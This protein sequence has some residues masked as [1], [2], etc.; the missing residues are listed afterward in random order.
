MGDG[1][2]TEPDR[3]VFVPP[4]WRIVARAGVSAGPG[5]HVLVITR[6][7]AFG[8]GRHPTTQLCLQALAAVGPRR[9]VLDFGSGSGILALAAARLSASARGVEID[10]RALAVSRDNAR[11][12]GLDGRVAFGRAVDDGTYD[13]LLANVVRPVL[14]EHAPRLVARLDPG[15]GVVLSGLLAT[16]VPDVTVRWSSLLGGRR[17]TVHARGEWRAVVWWP[18]ISAA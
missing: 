13:L 2:A 12:A 4:C 10:E 16:D 8:D 11:L 15:A 18:D 6:S 14:L 1:A 7:A 5:E 17:P 3:G 9:R